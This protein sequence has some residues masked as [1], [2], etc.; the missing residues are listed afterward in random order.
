[1]VNPEVTKFH[2]YSY[3]SCQDM[4][5]CLVNNSPVTDRQ[6]AMYKSTLCISTGAGGLKTKKLFGQYAVNGLREP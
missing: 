3:C 1:M 4:I 2:D 6:K 5:S